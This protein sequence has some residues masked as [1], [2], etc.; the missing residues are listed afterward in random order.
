MQNKDQA[1]YDKNI[2]S[3]QAIS[4]D[5]QDLYDS[6]PNGG[7]LIF[8]VIQMDAEKEVAN[9]ERLIFLKPKST[10]G[11]SI[12]TGKKYFQP[13][14]EDVEVSVS[15]DSMPAD[16][17]DEKFFASVVVTDYSSYLKVPK[18]K[19]QPSLP[20]MVY[21]EKE[22]QHQNEQ[23]DEFPYATEY[24]DDMFDSTMDDQSAHL[25][26]LLAMQQWR[27]NLLNDIENFKT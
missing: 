25:D 22:V 8:R 3:T 10:I 21:L 13:A 17:D 1:I 24:L 6:V 2:S 14:Q 23:I 16:T 19:Y 18:H 15:L 26:L 4:V 9:F 12:D 7:V 20:T 11:F 27:R 5:T